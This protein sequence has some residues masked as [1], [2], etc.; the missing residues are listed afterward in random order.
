MADV[1][2]RFR[3]EARFTLLNGVLLGARGPAVVIVVIL[4]HLG[5]VLGLCVRVSFPDGRAVD[6]GADGRG[7]RGRVDGEPLVRVVAVQVER[8]STAHCPRLELERKRE[9]R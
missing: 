2:D 3:C 1:H 5:V 4:A 9:T 7:E 8:L 6:V